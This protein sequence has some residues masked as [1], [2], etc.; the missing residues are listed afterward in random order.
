MKK[1]SN[2]DR[3]ME[4][5]DHFKNGASLK[6]HT[7][8]ENRKIA[9]NNMKSVLFTFSIVILSAL[10]LISC[11]KD[12]LPETL[13]VKELVINLSFSSG[14]SLKSITVVDGKGRAVP[15]SD[16]ANNWFENAT[17]ETLTIPSGTTISTGDS[18]VLSKLGFNFI[19]D[20][21]KYSIGVGPESKFVVMKTNAGKYNLLP[22][23][24]VKLSPAP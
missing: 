1:Y 14:F 2:F 13:T 17:L 5:G 23:E 22:E 10:F 8:R 4:A 21:E 18:K 20:G 12:N 6:S 11:E 19:V 7:S 9:I 15:F 24:T 16:N 3:V